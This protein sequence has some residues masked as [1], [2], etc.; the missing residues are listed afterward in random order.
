MLVQ[1]ENHLIYSELHL[2][3]KMSS[4]MQLTTIYFLLTL[5]K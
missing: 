2:F 4:I 3:K 5:S 1:F